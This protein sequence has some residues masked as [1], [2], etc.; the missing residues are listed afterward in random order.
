MNRA[1]INVIFAAD[2]TGCI[3]VAGKLPWRS[4]E[5][6]RRFKTL[7]LGGILI[8]GRKTY[9]SMP[10]LPGRELVV[11][12]RSMNILKGDPTICRSYEEAVDVSRRSNKTIFVIGGA[13]LYERAMQTPEVIGDVHYSCI[14]GEFEGDTY[15][16]LPPGLF[17]TV[18]VENYEDH[19]YYLLKVDTNG[20]SQYIRLLSSLVNKPDEMVEGR[21][22]TTFQN[23][24]DTMLRFD[25][26]DG[27]PL[28]TTKRMFF[29]GIVEELLMFLRGET[30]T[31][32]LE[33]K[34]INIWKGNTCR[35]FLDSINKSSRREGVMGPMYGY[36]WRHFDAEY[37]EDTAQPISPG[38]DQLKRVVNQ[39]INDP[40]SRRIL[41]TT[42][43]PKQVDDGVLP[44][45]HSIVT[46]FHVQDS[47]L[48]LACYNR[49]QDVFLGMPFNI[50]SSSL[51]LQIVASLTGLTP[52]Y[53]SL[54]GG[55]VHLYS[56]HVEAARSQ[57]SRI[58]FSF[59]TLRMRRKDV[60]I[61]TLSAADFVLEDYVHHPSIPVAMVS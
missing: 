57:I 19:T 47:F 16:K 33:D 24:G 17:R 60:D 6:L 53:F 14:H 8:V 56:T 28:L 41:M 3:G 31:K 40:T 36:Q 37:D 10:S 22:G 30:D 32:Q 9:E 42:F 7:T 59:P 54:I 35:S 15:F 11:V 49:S 21:N 52:R 25:L 4:S 51:L 29:R 61:D 39:I 44:P 43:N 34:K 23:F 13:Q 58:P 48:D 2:S 38:V 46:Q 12:S 26:R 20:E 1:L 27:F 50:A 5:D 18:R 45:C 55:C